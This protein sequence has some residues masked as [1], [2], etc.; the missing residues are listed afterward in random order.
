[1]VAKS[2]SKTVSTESATDAL[3]D[4]FYLWSDEKFEDLYEYGLKTR[5]AYIDRDTF[6][7]KMKGKSWGIKK[8]W[9]AIQNIKVVAVS[10]KLVTLS[11]EIGYRNKITL[12]EFTRVENFTLYPEGDRW[13]INL[14]KLLTLPRP[15]G[16]IVKRHKP[17]L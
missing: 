15:E 16:K 2:R 1:M 6:V 8:A 13:K 3:K 11:A 17:S 9:A 5:R 10:S 7:S 14:H 4:I 12:A